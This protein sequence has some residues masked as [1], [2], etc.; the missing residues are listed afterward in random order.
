V[1]WGIGLG[2]LMGKLTDLGIDDRFMKNV[3]EGMK[4][5][6]SA[7]FFLLRKA[8]TDKMLDVLSQF[9]GT[10]YQTSLSNEVEAALKAAVEHAD[11]NKGIEQVAA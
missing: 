5:G 8:T 11:F 2:A 6:S 9:K 10:V 3:A 4:P 7:I 1:L